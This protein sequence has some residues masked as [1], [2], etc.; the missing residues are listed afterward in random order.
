[1]FALGII[2]KLTP[3]ELTNGQHFAGTGTIDAAGNVG[4]IGGVEQKM[5]AARDA[6]ARFFLAP[7]ANC[8]EVAGNVP[9]DLV[10]VSI[11]TLDDA[12]TAV[13]TLAGGGSAEGLGSCTDGA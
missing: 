12:L 11:A 8:R 7:E 10:V 6:G 2:D 5:V 9:E 4:P 3:G 13:E 1:M